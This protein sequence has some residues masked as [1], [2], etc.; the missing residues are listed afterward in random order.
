MFNTTDKLSIHRLYG[1]ALIGLGMSITIPFI[2]TGFL[3]SGVIILY[4]TFR[5]NAIAQ[6]RKESW[7]K[8]LI[9]WFFLL[10]L[11]LIASFIGYKVF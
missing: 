4:K 2:S 5:V 11:S 1:V 7:K 6:I 10:L 3:I 9:G 8:S